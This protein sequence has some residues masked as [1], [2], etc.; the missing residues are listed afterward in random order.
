MFTYKHIVLVLCTLSIV[1]GIFW[2]GFGNK[3]AMLENSIVDK[4]DLTT[5]SKVNHHKVLQP[6]S[7]N[8]TLLAK[9]QIT[10]ERIEPWQVGTEYNYQLLLTNKMAMVGKSVAA[11]QTTKVIL[12]GNLALAMIDE[13]IQ[14]IT[15]RAE[16]DDL[17]LK[18]DNN[19]NHASV[20]WIKA[21]KKLHNNLSTPFYLVLERNGRVKSVRIPSKLTTTSTSLLRSIASNLQ[22]IHPQ[23]LNKSW[24][25]TE[26]DHVGEYQAQYQR[27]SQ[28]VYG[29][30]KSS[31]EKIVTPEGLVATHN[32]GRYQVDSQSTF[33]FDDL[34]GLKSISATEII[35]AQV[36]GGFQIDTQQEMELTLVSTDEITAKIP[37]WINAMKLVAASQ[38]A[39]IAAGEDPHKKRQEQ[40]VNNTD[41]NILMAE[42]HSLNFT[43]DETKASDQEIMGVR[44]KL[45]ALF[46]I[47]PNTAEQALAEF[48]KGLNMDQMSILAGALASA[49]TPQA[50]SAL[51]DVALKQELN[52]EIRTT[53]L[54]LLGMS[55][56]PTETTID[57]LL[58]LQ[59]S[60]EEGLSTT[61]NMA[62][63]SLSE[64]MAKQNP[65]IAE[66]IV[67]SLLQTFEKSDSDESR[68]MSLEALG[69]TGDERII[70]GIVSV[71][72]DGSEAIRTSA[73][74]AL[75]FVK[76]EKAIELITT[77]LEQD[78]QSNVRQAAIRAM[79]YH[80]IEAFLPNL[81]KIAHN[82][83]DSSVR[84]QIVDR[85]GE[86]LSELAEGKELL[87]WLADNDPD[88]T[89]REHAV[90][91]V[92]NFNPDSCEKETQTN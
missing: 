92:C 10:N 32:I 56:K 17:Q 82:D 19:S 21:K 3:V 48:D 81:I 88:P 41:I 20:D 68:L 44:R 6:F 59:K 22:F 42:L 66:Q 30:R 40:L 85:T 18:F 50:Q 31:Y 7:K 45:T 29:K 39:T 15:L 62:L 75:R 91:Y 27:V 11:Q 76:T 87:I 60:E 13:G 54:A 53:A 61:A 80:P 89:I 73:V 86:R 83:E 24:Q 16:I 79:D 1:T 65:E 35:S 84:L 36:M 28:G 2:G 4:K 63:G 46:A 14:T 78:A 37:E 74:E 34:A 71:L 52:T 57:T 47:H 64:V 72:N 25:Y 43:D 8:T 26:Q 58:M 9:N 67:T 23:R 77:T 70:P 90:D 5:Q 12:E 33:S 51:G 38:L 69:N 49:E 55:G